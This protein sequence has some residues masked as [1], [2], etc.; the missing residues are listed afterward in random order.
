[1]A[2]LFV[3]FL[4][5]NMFSGC[6]FEPVGLVIT[7]YPRQAYVKGESFS[8]DGLK[9]ETINAN[10]TMIRTYIDDSNISQV[11]MYSSGEKQIKIEKENLNISF[12]IYVADYVVDNKSQLKQTI[13]NANDGDIIYI[14]Q[15]EYKPDNSADESLYNIIINKKLV[16]IG[17]GKDKTVLHANF[18][19]GASKIEDNYIGL[20]NFEDVKFL[21]IGFKLDS[22][23]QNRYLNYEGPYQNFDLYGAIKT[24]DSQKIFVNNCSF[25]GYCYGINCD[26]VQD[27]T[28][29]N[30]IFEDIKVCAIKVNN[31][32][33]NSSIVKNSFRNIA[34][35][36]LTMQNSK[37]GFVSA[38]SLAFNKEGNAGVIV[39]ANNFSHIGQYSKELL[40]ATPGA[41]ELETM[42]IKLTSGMYVN[43]SSAVYLYSSSK[44]NLA[45]SGIVFSSNNFS[46]TLGKIR[47]G[48]T[49]DNIINQTG[50]YVYET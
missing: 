41:D 27:L 18:L 32:I 23:I 13:E 45:V 4:F 37:Q 12:N 9:I 30:C 35:S 46:G 33:K 10:G 47:F 1:M 43:R 21:N 7:N 6:A 48:T 20:N 42:D 2:I 3:C 25:F 34:N 17:D 22:Q 39:S 5:A 49:K 29:T 24:F 36:S 44:N 16:L 38:L 19:V 8:L 26:T 31:D 15:G 40:F 14:K 11:E 50:I 28:I